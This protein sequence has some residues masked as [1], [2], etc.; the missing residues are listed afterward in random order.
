MGGKIKNH[1]IKHKILALANFECL[2][3]VTIFGT[4]TLKYQCLKLILKVYSDEF[5]V[6]RVPF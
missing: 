3:S 1:F 6:V 5:L 4:I 2:I